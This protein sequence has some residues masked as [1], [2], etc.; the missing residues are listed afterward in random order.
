MS[1]LFKTAAL[2]FL[3]GLGWSRQQLLLAEINYVETLLFDV[4]IF[5]KRCCHRLQWYYA[6]SSSS[7]TFELPSS[8]SDLFKDEQEEHS[9]NNIF[10]RDDV[11]IRYSKMKRVFFNTSSTHPLQLL[12]V[13][14]RIWQHRYNPPSLFDFLI[15]TWKA[16]DWLAAGKRAAALVVF[17]VQQQCEANNNDHA[18][19]V[20]IH[21]GTG[22]CPTWQALLYCTERVRPSTHKFPMMACRLNCTTSRYTAIETT[23]E[24][25][26]NNAVSGGG[27]KPVVL[28]FAPWQTSM[29]SQ[30]PQCKKIR[31]I[32]FY[33]EH[34]PWTICG[35]PVIRLKNCPYPR[36][37]FHFGSSLCLKCS[38]DQILPFCR[39]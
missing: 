2:M 11:E 33:E 36:N 13:E 39:K 23:D 20:V 24:D 21:R 25:G 1:T 38:N 19:L 6:S 30:M 8:C 15:K 35:Q 18:S 26:S 12:K 27:N 16:L 4:D 7:F 34:K 17:V 10:S 9:K 3:K 14:T 28:L 22:K 5:S 32:R 31:V 29:I 37:G